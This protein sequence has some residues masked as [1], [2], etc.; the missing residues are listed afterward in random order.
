MNPYDTTHRQAWDLI[1]WLVNQTLSDGQR[2]QVEAHLRQCA[3]CRDERL[4][5]QNVHGGIAVD[6]VDSR[7]DS[8]VSLAQLFE[9]IDAEDSVTSETRRLDADPARASHPSTHA[10]RDRRR[11]RLGQML[12]AAVIIEA[13]GLV[14]LGM[15]LAGQHDAD[16]TTAAYST[17][18]ESGHT[19]PGA[20]VRLVPSPS[21]SIGE[22]QGMLGDAH[23]RIVDSNAAG[24]ILALAPIEPAD[25]LPSGN[26]R[27]DHQAQLDEAL[28]RLRGHAGVL[29]AEPILS[30]K[31][32]R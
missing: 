20:R 22:L 11:F 12:A 27:P 18:S 26:G 6:A 8:A 23:L 1:P 21:L 28:R 14:A 32:V 24:T 17:L 19:A 16:S 30:S 13:L 9:R 31:S 4:F 25:T 7:G 3:D 5:Q 15:M 10:S 2:E 29:L